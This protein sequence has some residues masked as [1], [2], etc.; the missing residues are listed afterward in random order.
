[1]SM[2]KKLNFPTAPTA[3]QIRSFGSTVLFLLFLHSGAQTVQSYQLPL[4]GSVK[5]S[6]TEKAADVVSV[7]D[8]GA[9]GNDTLDDTKAFQTAL[10]AVQGRTIYLHGGTYYCNF[11]ITKSNVRIDG[12]GSI[13]R[14]YKLGEPVIKIGGKKAINDI[15]LSFFEIDGQNLG[16]DGIAIENNHIEHG[17][18][19]LSFDRLIIMKCRYGFRISG[20]TIWSRFNNCRFDWNNGGFLISTALPCNLLY[21][22]N[23]TFNKNRNY[24]LWIENKNAANETFKTFQFSSCNFEGNGMEA[25]QAFGAWFSG[26]ELL[27]LENIYCENN[28]SHKNES[29][30]IKITGEAGRGFHISGGWY[31]GS[32]YPIYIDGEKKWGTIR[33]TTA[34]STDENAADIFLLSNW[35]NDEPKI[36]VEQCMGLVYTKPDNQGNL[37]TFGVDWEPNNLL[38]ISMQYRSWL[39]I[40]VKGNHRDVAEITGLVPGKTIGLINYSATGHNLKLASTLMADNKPFIIPANK[41]VQF[42]VDGY[43]TPGKLIPIITQ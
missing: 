17:S 1:M 28:G 15:H 30:G 10:D 6:I 31:V 43:P 9:N 25:T 34:E 8:F 42:L 29:Y 3:Y 38:S 39:K 21:F 36:D 26:M 24:G 37:P 16:G 33:N 23:C 11:A 19:F 40:F 41:A 12:N 35:A 14:P 32:K 5:R 20:R 7:E 13:L 2:L 18:D 27:L 4:N 22:A